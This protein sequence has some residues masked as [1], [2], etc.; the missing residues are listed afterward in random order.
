MIEE[1]PVGEYVLREITAPEGYQ[2]AEDVSFS[3]KETGEVQTVTMK[4]EREVT[5]VEKK[6]EEIKEKMVSVSTGDD[7][8]WT[9]WMLLSALIS[10]SVMLWVYRK[11]IRRFPR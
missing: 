4:D 2:I 3:V 9:G 8:T 1:L 11:R 6:E 7:G 5:P 10:G